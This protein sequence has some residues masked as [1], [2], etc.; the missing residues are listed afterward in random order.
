MA[1]R[2]VLGA[3]R[4]APGVPRGAPRAP[5][6][7]NDW[8]LRDQKDEELA[9]ICAKSKAFCEAWLTDTERHFIGRRVAPIQRRSHPAWMYTGSGDR[10]RLQRTNLFP[11]EVQ[12]WV[13]GITGEDEPYRLPPLGVPLV[14]RSAAERASR[15]E[16]SPQPQEPHD[17]V[18]P[19]ASGGSDAAATAAPTTPAAP[20]VP[21]T[22]SGPPARSILADMVLKLK[23]VGSSRKRGQT[24]TSPA[25]PTKKPRP[26]SGGGDRDAADTAVE[27][28]AAATGD[29]RVPDSS[30]QGTAR[31]QSPGMFRQ[32][33]RP[34]SSRAW[35]GRGRFVKSRR[36]LRVTDGCGGVLLLRR[37]CL[38]PGSRGA[39]RADMGLDHF[40]P[41]RVPAGTPSD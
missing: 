15:Q 4:R 24:S 26:T 40:R 5:K 14:R 41:Q 17:N 2:L 23:P 35:L 12:F 38:Q 8:T 16:A 29:P 31:R 20:P 36:T 3:H 37:S 7:S 18:G 28:A 19:G 34:P 32:R 6:D 39:R 33:P 27:T 1:P 25:A 11:E 13:K 30:S 21:R 22:R 10:T 9:L